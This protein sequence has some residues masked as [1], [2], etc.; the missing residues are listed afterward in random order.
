MSTCVQTVDWY[1]III[2]NNHCLTAYQIEVMKLSSTTF[3][4]SSFHH[5]PLGFQVKGLPYIP[6]YMYCYKFP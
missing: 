6:W 1:C 3:L 4:T 5:Y 2:P